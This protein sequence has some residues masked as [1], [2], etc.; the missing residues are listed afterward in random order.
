MRNRT[1][2]NKSCY[3]SDMS[4]IGGGTV[5]APLGK[6]IRISTGSRTETNRYFKYGIVP[7]RLRVSAL[8]ERADTYRFY[9]AVY[10]RQITWITVRRERR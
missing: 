1:V 10:V 5:P 3:L 9:F 7:S 8:A 4:A 6:D 2:V